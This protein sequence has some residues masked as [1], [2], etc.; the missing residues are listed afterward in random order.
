[1]WC[2][3]LPLLLLHCY[4]AIVLLP[5]SLVLRSSA[6]SEVFFFFGSGLEIF[7]F[8]PFIICVS[9]HKLA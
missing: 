1:M 8:F 3:S 6:I 4:F 5:N 9:C 2:A 7:F